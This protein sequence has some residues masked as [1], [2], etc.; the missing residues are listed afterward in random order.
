M[1]RYRKEDMKAA[2]KLTNAPQ[3]IYEMTCTWEG[4]SKNLESMHVFLFKN[5]NYQVW[6]NCFL[7][8]LNEFADELG[9]P[10]E[11]DGSVDTANFRKVRAKIE[12]EDFYAKNG[13]CYPR[14]VAFE[15]LDTPI[16]EQRT[17]KAM[18]EIE[19]PDVSEDSDIPF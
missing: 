12:V 14:C 11:S 10:V 16:S 4:P 1:A 15:R 19:V 5:E 17:E 6:H 3:G 2:E 8:K 7:S 9:V 18:A 13:N